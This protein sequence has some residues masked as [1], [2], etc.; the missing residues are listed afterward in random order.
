MSQMEG[1]VLCEHSVLLFYRCVVDGVSSRCA[2]AAELLVVSDPLPLH[3][4]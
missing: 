2:A 1:L 3:G 4:L